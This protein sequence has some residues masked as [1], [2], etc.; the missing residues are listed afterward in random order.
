MTTALDTRRPLL[1]RLG[2]RRAIPQDVG[3]EER[4]EAR[5]DACDLRID[6]GTVARI[7]ARNAI[8]SSLVISREPGF[9]GRIGLPSDVQTGDPKFDAAVRIFGPEKLVLALCDP[10]TR[11]RLLDA[12]HAG[13]T[14]SGGVV[15]WT[16]E[17]PWLD[18]V[19]SERAGTAVWAA[20]SLSLAESEAD[21]RLLSRFAAEP[22]IAVRT[23]I[24]LALA[25]SGPGIPPEL[26]AQAARDPNPVLHALVKENL[27]RGSIR[28]AL[29]PLVRDPRI[30]ED[31]RRAALHVLAPTLSDVELRPLLESLLDAETPDLTVSALSF[32]SRRRLPLPLPRRLDLLK[33]HS[34][35]IQEAIAHDLDAAD[36]AQ[37]RVLLDLL[38]LEPR[39]AIAALQSLGRGAGLA[40]V[41]AILPYTGSRMG[42]DTA[43]TVAAR[44][45]VA[46]IRA[47]HPGAPGAVSIA[48]EQSDG[49]LSIPPAAGAVS[50]S[51]GK[52]R[53]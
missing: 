16:H 3:I 11:P 4:L 17:A 43:F 33:G 34:V 52:D 41:E 47:R 26:I 14:V 46:Q 48:G 22:D 25:G 8:D 10:A 39:V 44:D 29:E 24:F 40:A 53:G 50:T 19:L 45:A 20:D 15:S 31:I 35:P 38:T 13:M 42:F 23:R 18:H 28:P 6:F 37:E 12:V 36:P 49:A 1:H 21:A 9:L 7:E 5:I 27:H 30:A 2:L 32:A 51:D